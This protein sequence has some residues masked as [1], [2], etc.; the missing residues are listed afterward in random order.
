M[1]FPFLLVCL[2][3]CRLLLLDCSLHSSGGFLGCWRSSLCTSSA[4][5]FAFH[6]HH[7]GLG[8][9]DLVG[10]LL[11]GAVAGELANISDVE[12]HHLKPLPAV[13]VDVRH[14]LLALDVGL[15]VGKQAVS[16]GQ[17]YSCW[18]VAIGPCE[19]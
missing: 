16:A 13:L 3:R 9:P 8:P 7:T 2:I 6:W 12:Y 18:A 17:G 19:V 4:A 14:S 1:F 11:D 15:V 10:I 5:G